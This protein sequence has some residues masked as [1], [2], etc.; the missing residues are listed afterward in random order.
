VGAAKQ[1]DQER[2]WR[3]AARWLCFRLNLAWWYEKLVM[4]LLGVAVLGGAVAI[5]SRRYDW[6]LGESFWNGLLASLALA[7]FVAHYRAR[8][9]YLNDEQALV[10]LEADLGLNN[11]LS[12][13][14]AGRGSWPVYEKTAVVNWRP[15]WIVLPMLAAATFLLVGF[16]VPVQPLVEIEAEN[17]PYLW[18]KLEREL[19][20]LVAEEMI[21]EDYAE[22]VKKRLEELREQNAGDWFS[23]ASLEAT[24]SLRQAHQRE[25]NRLQRDLMKVEQALRKAGDP[26]VTAAQ[27][28][29]L[30]Q[31]FEEA[32][33]GMR[34]G[35]MKPNEDLMKKL[36]EAAREGMKGM[37]DAQQQALRERLRQ[38]ADNLGKRQGAGPEGQG[39]GGEGENPGG[40]RP[41]QGPGQGE[42]DRGPGDGGDLFGA[43]SPELKLKKFESLEGGQKPEP[44][45]GDLLNLEEIEHDQDLE[46][47]GPTTSGAA[48]SEGLGG[49]RVWKDQLDPDEQKSLKSFFE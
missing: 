21:Q 28:Q 39:P 47:R 31:Q 13:A 1:A 4:P 45:P 3:K 41:G 25:L 42:P 30:R 40:Q 24:D 12:T 8:R 7:G 9:H 46:A 14:A 43:D 22:T 5:A 38:M 26:N 2:H 32:M 15:G 11:A 16:M 44:D 37:S 35:Q 48:Q 20:E 6:Q 36:A 19:A 18:G 33:E 34:N 17:Q 10:R 29:K 49:D 23:A 27:R